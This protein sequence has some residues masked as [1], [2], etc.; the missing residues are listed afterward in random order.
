M[1]VLHLRKTITRDLYS[2][3]ILANS[4]DSYVMKKSPSS[5]C[6]YKTPMSCNVIHLYVD[7]RDMN[8]Q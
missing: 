7:T 4:N 2:P 8:V 1:D 3:F 6:Y 5:Q